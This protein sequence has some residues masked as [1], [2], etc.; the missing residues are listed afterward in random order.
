[1]LAAEGDVLLPVPLDVASEEALERTAQD[2]GVPDILIN[3]AGVMMLG[4]VL[5]ADTSEWR[6]MVETNI[7]GLM[8]LSRAALL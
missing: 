6:R 1:V 8:Y 3:N 4:P 5:I 2:L 7:L